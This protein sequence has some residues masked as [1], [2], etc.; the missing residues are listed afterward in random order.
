MTNKFIYL[1]PG[2]WFELKNINAEKTYPYDLDALKN[3]IINQVNTRAEKLSFVDISF[4]LSLVIAAKQLSI[5]A[6]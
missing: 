1:V 6:G 4:T 5:R 2:N 3:E